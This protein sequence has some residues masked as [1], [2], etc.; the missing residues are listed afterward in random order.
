MCIFLLLLSSFTRFWRFLS[1]SLE[2][3]MHKGINENILQLFSVSL[4]LLVLLFSAIYNNSVF[5][6]FYYL[7]PAFIKLWCAACSVHAEFAFFRSRLWSEFIML[8]DVF[9]VRCKLLANFGQLDFGTRRNLQN[10]IKSIVNGEVREQTFPL[11]FFR[12]S[13][14]GDVISFH[15]IMSPAGACIKARFCSSSTPTPPSP[16]VALL[17]PSV[18]W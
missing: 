15:F 10:N 11:R 14:F 6:R 9:Y 4:L 13:N 16:T 3:T 1:S 8:S 2:Q 5:Q 7:A 18:T 17:S 12:P